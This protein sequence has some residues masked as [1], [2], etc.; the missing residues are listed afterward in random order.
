MS[1]W[2]TRHRFG[3]DHWGKD[4][5]R[6]LA[7][8]ARQSSTAKLYDLKEDGGASDLQFVALPSED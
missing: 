4:Q 3:I 2:E 6:Q 8:A 5:V 1:R 7:R